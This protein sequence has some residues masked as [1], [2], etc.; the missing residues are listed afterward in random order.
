MFARERHGS[1]C[2]VVWGLEHQALGVLG[3]RVDDHEVKVEIEPT[4]FVKY[5]VSRYDLSYRSV[6]VKYQISMDWRYLRASEV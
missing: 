5:Q 2:N 4:V 6:T 1:I 3:H